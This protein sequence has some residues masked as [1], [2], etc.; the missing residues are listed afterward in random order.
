[1]YD[2]NNRYRL[3]LEL[4]NVCSLLPSSQLACTTWVPSPSAPTPLFPSVA[5]PFLLATSS[6]STPS[7]SAAAAAAA[8]G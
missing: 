7:S 4:K 5:Q 6:P 2:I 3:V 8:A 1:M